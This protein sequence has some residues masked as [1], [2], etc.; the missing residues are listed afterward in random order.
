MAT[1]RKI[2]VLT[3]GGDAP[4]MNA[5]IRA[6]V[7]K[8]TEEGMEAVGILGG[9]SGLI[10]KNLILLTAR[11]VSNIIS[12]SGTMLYSDRCPE[13]KTEEGMQKAIATCREA[14]IDAIVAVG[15]DGT[16]RGAT[17]L[18]NRGVPTVGIPGTIDNDITATDY[19]IGFDSAMTTTLSMIDCL[20]NTC[21]SHARCDVIE[22]M[23]RDCGQIALYTALASG[24]VA[25]V[26]PELPFDENE[27]L[28]RI[29]YLRSCGKRSFLVVVS[30]GVFT[31]DG[32]KYS[33]VL[34]KKIQE[35]TGVETKFARF[36]HVVR[37][38]IPTLRDRLTATK[39]G[40]KAVELLL[41]GR[42]NAVIC[43]IDG[44]IVD[45]DI[46]YALIADRNYKNKLK[47]G[48]L[49]H[50]TAEQVEAMKALAKKRH[51]ELLEVSKIIK[52]TSR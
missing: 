5:I 40:V 17:D 24:A 18:T 42:S 33:E 35:K 14:Q 8:A 25:A 36:A 13:F 47:P 46:N 20:R 34:A 43:E 7:R 44:A 10:H 2:G 50:F 12:N 16:F 37:G 52:D 30:E 15:G 29:H 31:P 3:S 27:L 32:G 48:D 21:E 1:F 41:A 38:G 26:I 9:F 6:V 45:T 22:V 19:T 39:M 23:G 49:D 28:S 51:N 4:G 11:S